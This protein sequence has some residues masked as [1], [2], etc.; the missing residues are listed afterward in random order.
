[1][2]RLKRSMTAERARAPAREAEREAQ[3]RDLTCGKMVGTRS[4]LCPPDKTGSIAN[5]AR[6]AHSDKAFPA[7]QPLAGE[8]AMKLA[9]LVRLG[10]EVVVGLPRELRLQLEC[11]VDRPHARELFEE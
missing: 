11:L 5:S 2:L 8:F 1:M 10:D 6:L 9:N 4:R 7:L 3:L